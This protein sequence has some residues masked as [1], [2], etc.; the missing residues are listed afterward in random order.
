MTHLRCCCSTP[1]PN[2]C[3]W[4]RADWMGPCIVSMAWLLRA[5]QKPA[6]ECP[7]GTVNARQGANCACPR[8]RQ[9]ATAEVHGMASLH[10]WQGP[11]GR[12]AGPRRHHAIVKGK[13]SI[14]LV[15][16]RGIARG[17]RSHPGQF[18]SPTGCGSGAKAEGKHKL[19]QQGSQRE[20]KSGGTCVVLGVGK[21]PRAQG[22]Y[23][24]GWALLCPYLGVAP[25]LDQPPPVVSTPTP[26]ATNACTRPC[27][28]GLHAVHGL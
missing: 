18:R 13:G 11:W 20:A 8:S 2:R 24:A 5:L 22:C 14:V 21:L 7:L 26:L 15:H 19:N 10:R 17:H 12:H 4:P 28:R 23:L 6:G 3:R 27:S 1:A 25:C 9:R 16:F